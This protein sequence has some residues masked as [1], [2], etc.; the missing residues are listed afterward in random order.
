[1]RLGIVGLG[2]GG[3]ALLQNAYKAG[4]DQILTYDTSCANNTLSH[5]DQVDVMCLSA[6]IDV[7]KADNKIKK[8]AQHKNL[9]NDIELFFRHKIKPKVIAV[10]G[11]YGKSSV[12]FYINQVLTEHGVLN[13][14]VGNIGNPIWDYFE[15]DGV[16]VLELSSYQLEL[17]TSLK[18]QIGAITNIYPHHLAR[19]KV[20]EIYA[21]LKTKLLDTSDI[22]IDNGS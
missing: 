5:I 14:M 12:V 3:K 11:S 13:K 6:G 8:L 1:M 15:Y 10:T 7:A 17:L 9:V 18:A 21:Q 4:Y 16:F 20:F 22:S 19:H 2:V